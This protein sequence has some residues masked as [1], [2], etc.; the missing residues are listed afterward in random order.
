MKNVNF[1]QTLIIGSYI[2]MF[3]LNEY[4]RNNRLPH[5]LVKRIECADGFSI[6]VQGHDG[7][8]CL[9]RIDDEWGDMEYSH[10][11][12]GFPSAEPEFIMD[13]VEDD[14]NPTD[15]VYGYVPVDLVEALIDLHNNKRLLVLDQ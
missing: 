7:A 2:K 11:E 1:I 15:T 8:Y 9:P 13:Y 6:S 3:N 12:C 14:N 4:F 5:G 10:V